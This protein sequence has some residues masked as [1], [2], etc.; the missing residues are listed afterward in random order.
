MDDPEIQTE[1][2]VF[3]VC[4]SA[5][6]ACMGHLGCNPVCGGHRGRLA[7]V[8]RPCVAITC[9]LLVLVALFRPFATG[10]ATQLQLVCLA[11]QLGIYM[12]AVGA[13]CLSVAEDQDNCETK[14][15]LKAAALVAEMILCFVVLCVAVVNLRSTAAEVSG[16]DDGAVTISSQNPLHAEDGEDDDEDALE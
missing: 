9:G 7:A 6:Q 5:V 12:Y 8:D 14:A 10:K 3:R 2:L 11:A 4:V 15:G 13:G 16:Q 1:L